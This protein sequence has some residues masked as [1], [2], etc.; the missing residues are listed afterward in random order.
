MST[1]SQQYDSL[2]CDSDYEDSQIIDLNN[3]P[4]DSQDEEIDRSKYLKYK[5]L[6]KRAKPLDYNEEDDCRIVSISTADK[7]LQKA[8]K[9][10]KIYSVPLS[11][12]KYADAPSSRSP[13]LPTGPPNTA[14][15]TAV[16]AAANRADASGPQVPIPDSP[17]SPS[18]SEAAS[19][20]D[21]PLPA[22]PAPAYSTRK[23]VFT[24][25]ETT[26]TL[27][28][29]QDGYVTATVKRSHD[30]QVMES[31]KY[32]HLIVILKSREKGAKVPN[33]TASSLCSPVT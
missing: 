20:P 6:A 12:I 30:Q 4:P 28:E 3:S 14:S 8:A 22:N 7:P 23:T 10:L 19:L 18:P 16:K 31:G 15:A 29:E 27:E 26:T 17:A 2:E 9:Q 1:Q 25:D 11:K 33:M 32:Y 21:I 24:E 5:K 13:I